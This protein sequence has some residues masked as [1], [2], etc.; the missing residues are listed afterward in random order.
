MELKP[1]PSDVDSTTIAP[2]M[3]LKPIV[4]QLKLHTWSRDFMKLRLCVLAQQEHSKRQTDRPEDD[5]LINFEKMLQENGV[6]EDG[7]ELGLK[8]VPS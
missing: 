2:Q 1:H 4:S 8:W 3:G 7:H 6:W 5:L